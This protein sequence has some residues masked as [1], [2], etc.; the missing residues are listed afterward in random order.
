MTTTLKRAAAVLSAVLGLTLTIGGLWLATRVGTSS[1]ATF[2]GKP[3]SAGAVLLTPQVLNR[4]DA[5]VRITATAQGGGKVWLGATTP[6]DAKAVLGDSA[7]FE[8][9]GAQLSGRVL[10]LRSTGAGATPA[11]G[12]ADIWRDTAEGTGSASMTV[13][14]TLAPDAVVVTAEQGKVATVSIAVQRKAWF[15]QSLIVT[16]I[17]LALVAAALLLWRSAS[18]ATERHRSADTPRRRDEAATS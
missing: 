12:Q 1:T 17:G 8:A 5:D 4:L 3:Q 7:R 6:S 9:S 18:H 11:I 14:Q 10:T 13:D 16:L 2:T 15:A